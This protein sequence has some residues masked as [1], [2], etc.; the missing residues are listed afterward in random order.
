MGKLTLLLVLAA[1]VGG[2]L[3]TMHT[4]G[5]LGESSQRYSEGQAD[6]L[7]RQIAESGQS[8]ALSRLM[9]PGGFVNPHLDGARAFDGGS[10]QVAVDE[11]AADGQTATITVTGSYGGAIHTIQSTYQFDPMDA[12][13]PLWLDVP[14]ATAS[15]SP[16][17]RINGDSAHPVYFDRRSYDELQLA[18]LL[19]MSRL[20]SDLGAAVS[21][22]RN[23]LQVPAGDEWAGLLEDLDRSDTMSDTEG[24]YQA[25]VAAFDAGTDTKLSGTQTVTGSTTWG[26]PDEITFVQ[27]DLNIGTGTVSGSVRGQGALVVRGA[28]RVREKGALRWDGLIIIRDTTNVLPIELNG[29]VDIHGAVAVAHQAIAPGGHLDVSVY[30]DE[31]GMT[32]SAPW[33]DV[34]HRVSP[35]SGT[36]YP[37]HQHTHAFDITPS[38]SPRGSHVYFMENG[39]AGRHDFETQFYSFVQSLGSE[40]VYLEFGNP[41]NHGFARYTVDVDGLPVP[42]T[43]TVRTGFGGFASATSPTRSKTFEAHDL[44]ALDLDVLSLRAL[45]QSFDTVDGCSNWPVCIGQTWDR[46]DA[47]AVRLVRESDGQRL[48]EASFY[49]HMRTDE[50]A[51]HTAEEAA[52]RSAILGGQEFGTHVTLGDD[53]E[54]TYDLGR[55][56]LLTDKLGFD[57]NE[58]IT[59]A[60]SSTHLTAAE[61]RARGAGAVCHTDRTVSSR[62]WSGFLRRS[63]PTSTTATRPALPGAAG[64]GIGRGA[65]NGNS[66]RVLLGT[67]PRG[68]TRR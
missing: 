65:R 38:A 11:I 64:H 21:T 5:A 43:G 58:I 51:A 24:L 30:R 32:S 6:L 50:Q 45:R 68:R 3:L 20:Q 48:Y 16:D 25:A 59:V 15:I 56:A 10:F 18:G 57:G 9:G 44:D 49:W 34:S 63:A 4:R 55:I 22:A 29:D 53:V 40:K 1:V 12:P 19:P 60:T 61:A 23:T 26:A 42:A 8:L 35:W 7:A 67:D 14:Y 39:A 54:I 17:A 52:W 27:G 66:A 28:L 46:K 41:E 47:L 62:R 37:F 2:S 33:G 13:G 36:N 31:R